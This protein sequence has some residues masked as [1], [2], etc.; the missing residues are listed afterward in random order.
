MPAMNSRVGFVIN[1]RV[2]SLN[3]LAKGMP[4]YSLLTGWDDR[5]S[6]MSLMRFRWLA[7]DL[8]SRGVA[9]YRLFAPGKKF[10]AVVFL[11]SMTEECL[12]LATRL[13]S[14]GTK[15][16]FDANVDYYT[17]GNAHKGAG[18]CHDELR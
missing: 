14:E 1:S 13:R 18:D 17:L 3:S 10:G 15:V 8:R 7:D 6:P 9:D 11:K 2:P 5:S 12:Q 16:V 4:I